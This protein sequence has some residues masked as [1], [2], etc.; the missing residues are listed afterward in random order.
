MVPH[1]HALILLAGS[2]SSTAKKAAPPS[3]GSN[4]SLLIL[5]AIVALGYF[6]F[7]RPRSRAAQAQRQTLSTLTAGDEVLTGAGIYGTVLDVYPDRVTIET[8]PGTRMTVARSTV[9]RKVEQAGPPADGDG[10]A[11]SDLQA[12]F[13]SEDHDGYG[14]D[15]G[16]EYD[17]DD[18]YEDEYDGG[19][20]DEYGAE[21]EDEDEHDHEAGEATHDSDVT[22]GDGHPWDEEE[23]EDE[24]VAHGGKGQQS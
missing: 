1:L 21:D 19:D 23:E 15:H 10:V 18:E 8:A 24:D 4:Y 11:V 16:N 20:E 14:E 5:L 22:D 17:A 12:Q 7:I 13:G 2:T 3:G 9:S 6:L